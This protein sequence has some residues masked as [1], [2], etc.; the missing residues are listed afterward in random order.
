MLDIEKNTK[1]TKKKFRETQKKEEFEFRASSADDNR[2]ILCGETP[3]RSQTIKQ[4]VL[5][6]RF[7]STHRAQHTAKG[8]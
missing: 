6:N 4:K 5:T 7:D 1:K 8:K 2:N 3:R